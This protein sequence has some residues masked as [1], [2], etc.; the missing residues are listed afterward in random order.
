MFSFTKLTSFFPKAHGSIHVN[1][2][3]LPCD[4]TDVMEESHGRE[5]TPTSTPSLSMSASPLKKLKT[6]GGFI[7]KKQWVT[8]PRVFHRR[9]LTSF[10]PSFKRPSSWSSSSSTSKF[11]TCV[12]L[13]HVAL[14]FRCTKKDN[15]DKRQEATT[16]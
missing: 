6:M 4:S 9:P 12:S 5:E 14:L 1:Q 8:T 11:R 3:S 2:K 7:R 16:S 13:K 15:S 10:L